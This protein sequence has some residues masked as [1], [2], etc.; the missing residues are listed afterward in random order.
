MRQV[1]SGWNDHSVEICARAGRMREFGPILSQQFA[2]DVRRPIPAPPLRQVPR[3][4]IRSQAAE[5]AQ[6][7]SR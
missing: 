1:A 4:E 7:V 2:H 3:S 6:A 5:A